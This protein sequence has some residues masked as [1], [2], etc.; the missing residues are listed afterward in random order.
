MVNGNLAGNVP[1]IIKALF[2]HLFRRKLRENHA[3]YGFG[4]RRQ[5]A[6][7]VESFQRFYKHLLLF[8]GLLLLEGLLRIS[9]YP[10]DRR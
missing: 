9:H 8:H 4:F 1:G 6:S 3:I 10:L 7:N 5:V 2:R